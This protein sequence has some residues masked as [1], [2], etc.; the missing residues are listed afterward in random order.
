MK[1]RTAPKRK[2]LSLGMRLRAFAAVLCLVCT[3]FALVSGVTAESAHARWSPTRRKTKW[4][5]GLVLGGNFSAHYNRSV[6]L[7]TPPETLLGE[8]H[9]TAWYNTSF[10]FY[11]LYGKSVL[12]ADAT[13]FGGG[14][15]Y[16]SCSWE[17]PR[18]RSSERP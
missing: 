12:Y 16:R 11:G 1:N 13:M 17:R 5:F 15:K 2:I 14:L 3:L 6:V 8:A 4:S 9:V 18:S 10:A 7:S